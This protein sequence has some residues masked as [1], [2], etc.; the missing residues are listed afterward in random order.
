M[1]VILAPTL[2]TLTTKQLQ[3]AS[4][5]DM[6]NLSGEENG[7]CVYS[8]LQSFVNVNSCKF[9]AAVVALK[10]EVE[11]EARSHFDCSGLYVFSQ[12]EMNK[13]TNSFDNSNLIGEG[14]LGMMPMTTM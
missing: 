11:D 5:E 4:E 3:H 13:A 14:T 2:Y 9:V 12:D 1:L 6:D 10:K 8:I 7:V